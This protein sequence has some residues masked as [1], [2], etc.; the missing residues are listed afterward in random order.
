MIHFL[1]DLDNT[2]KTL[3][4]KDDA[5]LDFREI[6]YS[7][8]L[9][10]KLYSQITFLGVEKVT[11][12][13][14]N[15]LSS[16]LYQ[17]GCIAFEVPHGSS[18]LLSTVNQIDIE[19]IM[20]LCQ[21]AEI[22]DLKFTDFL[23]YVDSL[24]KKNVCYVEK[25]DGMFRLVSVGNN[26]INFSICS[27]SGYDERLAA[28]NNA[29]NLESVMMVSDLTCIDN[30]MFFT[31]SVMVMDEDDSNL[32][33]ALSVFAWACMET[34]I[35]CYDS[36]VL[37]N[38]TVNILNSI[39]PEQASKQ[40]ISEDVDISWQFEAEMNDNEKEYENE[41]VTSHNKNI[42]SFD[43]EEKSVKKEVKK[44]KILNTVSVLILLLGLSLLVLTGVLF[45]LYKYN[46]LQLDKLQQD[47]GSASSNLITSDSILTAYQNCLNAGG[48]EAI[49]MYDNLIQTIHDADG[50]LHSITLSSECVEVSVSFIKK[51]SA[52]SFITIC[53]NAGY[54]VDGDLTIMEDTTEATNNMENNTDNNASD[55]ATENSEQSEI[56]LRVI[57]TL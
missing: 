49:L 55:N 40:D 44:H 28:F 25:Y 2:V 6:S 11:V 10:D 30:L 39:V 4:L 8:D 53:Q 43:K 56:Y 18:V 51:D 36:T 31:N 42:K 24:H 34:G 13:T 41:K 20:N 15:I 52:S 29:N 22:K 50:V 21:K 47:L 33:H 46:V 23:G 1:I 35:Y 7:N 57:K 12:I 38:S 14:H 32:I 5:I 19:Q 9:L 16:C 27:E 37:K 48:N 45:V 54:T 26:S 17:N 3:L